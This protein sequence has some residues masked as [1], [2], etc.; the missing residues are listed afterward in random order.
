MSHALDTFRE[1]L[2]ELKATPQKILEE[3]FI[4]EWF[5]DYHHKLPPFEEYY[6]NLYQVDNEVTIIARQSKSKVLSYSDLR[7]ALFYPDDETNKRSSATNKATDDRVIKLAKVAAIALLD[8]LH[9]EAKATWKYLSVSILEYSWAHCPAKVKAALLGLTATIDYC[10][11]A[12]GGVTQVIKNGGRVNIAGAAAQ[13]DTSCNGYLDKKSKKKKYKTKGGK[14]IEKKEG[15]F[16]SL[17]E[18]YV[19]PLFKWQLKMLHRQGQKTTLL[20][21]SSAK[22]V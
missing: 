9:N 18:S 16:H 15:L 8:E 2:M 19:M 20:W 13:S 3:D 17:N 7:Q 11:S 5:A 12:L 6:Q 4:M 10:E 1:K 22:L 14:K 21:R